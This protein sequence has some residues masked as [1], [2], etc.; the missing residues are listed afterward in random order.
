MRDP[1][2]QL[3]ADLKQNDL[4]SASSMHLPA[5]KQLKLTG[6]EGVCYIQNRTKCYVLLICMDEYFR[7]S[8]GQSVF[9]TAGNPSTMYERTICCMEE[10]NRIHF[11]DKQK[12]REG[13]QK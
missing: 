1:R 6:W 11:P 3:P 7:K 10:I 13:V 9:A 8:I 4:L 5:L 12:I 2:W